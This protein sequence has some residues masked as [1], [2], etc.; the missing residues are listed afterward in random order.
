MLLITTFSPWTSPG[1]V[2]SHPDRDRELHSG[3]RLVAALPPPAGNV[4]AGKLAGR[5]R[6]RWRHFRRRRS[7]VA[8]TVHPGERHDDGGRPRRRDQAVAGSPPRQS[9]AGGGI[10]G[11]GRSWA[12]GK[13]IP[14]F[15][16]IS[17]RELE[18]KAWD[19]WAIEILE[20]YST[21]LYTT[22][23]WALL[24]LSKSWWALLRAH[25][26]LRCIDLFTSSFPSVTGLHTGSGIRSSSIA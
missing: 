7:V 22:F 18:K 1:P 26:K 25:I 16:L 20:I 14:A 21:I 13:L 23:V 5:R 8:Q 24:S 11:S 9:A 6:R 12:T 2:L 10:L 17:W 3:H 19:H 4:E 15:D